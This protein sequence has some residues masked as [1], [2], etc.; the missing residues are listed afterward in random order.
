M[1][2]LKA[3]LEPFVWGLLIGYFWY[4]IWKIAKKIASEACKAKEEWNVK[5]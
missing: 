5:R 1:T 2:E 4:P 3:W